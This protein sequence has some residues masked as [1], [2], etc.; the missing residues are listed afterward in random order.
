MDEQNRNQTTI[1]ELEQYYQDQGS[2]NNFRT[3]LG[4][5]LIVLIIVGLA[6]SL[7]FSG[8]WLYRS[9]VSNDETDQTTTSQTETVTSSPTDSEAATT[10]SSTNGT[11]TDEAATTNNSSI[12]E[13]DIDNDDEPTT[14]SATDLPDTGAGDTALIILVTIAIGYYISRRKQLN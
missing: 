10:D 4:I 8:R 14:A 9:L 7:F 6:V 12:T 13:S 1:A 11:V 5:F 2:S 3:A